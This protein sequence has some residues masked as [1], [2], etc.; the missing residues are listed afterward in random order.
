MLLICDD[1]WHP[2]QVPIDGTVPLAGQGY[3]FDIVTNAN[4]FKPDILSQYPVVILCKC[5]EVSQADK[6]SWKTDAVQRAFID[7]VENGGGLLAVHSATVPGKNTQALD[8]LLGCRFISHPNACPV[9]V[10]PVKPHPVT[11]GVGM[12]CETDE[13]YRLELIEPDVD[14]LLASYS[15]PQGEEGKYQEDPYHNTPAFICPSGFV[16]KQGKGRI[17]VLTPGHNLAVWINPHFQ[18][19]LSNALRWCAGE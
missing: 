16:R 13:H 8:H 12:F 11:E 19:T 6:Q 9:T 2:G 15:P 18:R 1:Y 10:Q 7:Y 3:Q 17:C 5:D 14:V 4:N